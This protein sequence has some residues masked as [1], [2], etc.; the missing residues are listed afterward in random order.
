MGM[1][2]YVT[3]NLVQSVMVLYKGK[4]MGWK[5]LIQFRAAPVIEAK[6]ALSTRI[7]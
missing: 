3:V 4:A 6:S 5:N 1:D 7:S 2:K